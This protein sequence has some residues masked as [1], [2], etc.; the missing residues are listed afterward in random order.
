[1]E[2]NNLEDD[3][4]I[5]FEWREIGCRQQR[6][7]QRK[8]RVIDA[9]RK[10]ESRQNWKQLSHPLSEIAGL[11]GQLLW[12]ADWVAPCVHWPSSG[13]VRAAA[14]R[15]GG[16]VRCA[17]CQGQAHR[18]PHRPPGPNQATWR[19]SD[20]LK[21]GWPSVMHRLLTVVLLAAS[22][23]CCLGYCRSLGWNPSFNGPPLVEQVHT[24]TNNIKAVLCQ[25]LW[26]DANV[27][28]SLWKWFS[29]L[30]FTFVL[31][32]LWQT[33]MPSLTNCYA[34]FDKHLQCWPCVKLS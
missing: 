11:V 27:W 23:P 20:N 34:L 30:V 18:G 25:Q 3:T 14:S 2:L 7:C 13:I 28:A 9:G 16:F 17:H 19:I 15:G 24:N 33:V 21:T 10:V 22:L 8:S 12:P 6:L 31:C 4:G 1:M 29:K 5:S 32:P 26:G